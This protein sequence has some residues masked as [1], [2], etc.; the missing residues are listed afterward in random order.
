MGKNAVDLQKDGRDRKITTAGWVLFFVMWGA[1]VL[2]ERSSQ[3]NLQNIQY[4]GAGFILLGI[5]GTRLA[6][7]IPMSR[8]TLVIGILAV[9]GGLLLQTQGE[10][11]IYAMVAVTVVAVAAAEGILRL[12]K[13][14]RSRSVAAVAGGQ[15]K[16]RSRRR[17]R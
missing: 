10:L 7:A 2:V 14:L 4:V 16:G 3:V 9:A 13:L 12:Q 1:T 17:K 15:H 8:L 6:M 5:N 11:P